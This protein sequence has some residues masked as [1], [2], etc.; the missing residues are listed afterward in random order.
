LSRLFRRSPSKKRS[1]VTTFSAQFPP[2]EWTE[3]GKVLHLHSVAVQTQFTDCATPG[4]LLEVSQPFKHVNVFH[5]SLDM[6]LI[7]FKLNQ[8]K[9]SLHSDILK[10]KNSLNLHN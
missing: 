1:S 10:A 7:S 5:L 2:P 6:R 9:I 8:I 4:S 3:R